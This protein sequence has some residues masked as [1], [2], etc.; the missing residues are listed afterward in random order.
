ML[1]LLQASNDVDNAMEKLS[2]ADDNQ[3]T[4]TGKRKNKKPEQPH[5]S[6]KKVGPNEN[7]PEDGGSGNKEIK[8]CAGP[9][10]TKP[11]QQP[12]KPAGGGQ[13][14]DDAKSE[15]GGS[16]TG[17]ARRNRAKNKSRSS[18]EKAVSPASKENQVI[19]AGIHQTQHF[20]FKS[21]TPQ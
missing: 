19:G 17:T 1:L 10:V 12:A 21:K 6:A 14:A 7:L 4:G 5:Y 11:P 8:D 13:A 9:V 18:A 20:K 3:R 2:V 16:N 15:G